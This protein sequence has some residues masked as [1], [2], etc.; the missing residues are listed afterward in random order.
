MQ[1]EEIEQEPNA[2][3]ILHTIT[4]YRK[5]GTDTFLERIYIA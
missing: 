3:S 1:N 5:N 4:S 2:V